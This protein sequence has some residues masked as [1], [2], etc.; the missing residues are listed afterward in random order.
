MPALLSNVWTSWCLTDFKIQPPCNSVFTFEISRVFSDHSPIY[1]LSTLCVLI[2]HFF[3]RYWHDVWPLHETK[4]DL[5]P[6]RLSWIICATNSELL[7]FIWKPPIQRALVKF[8]QKL[9]AVCNLW[10]GIYY[11]VAEVSTIFTCLFKG[12]I[13]IDS[14]RYFQNITSFQWCQNNTSA[15]KFCTLFTINFNQVMNK[16]QLF[17]HL[18]K[19]SLTWKNI[20]EHVH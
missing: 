14:K 5:F 13:T 3:F 17:D 11:R 7:S 2:H 6:W 15:W 16:C 20:H 1:T 10:E 12:I 4:K 9:H 19:K 18:R 8:I